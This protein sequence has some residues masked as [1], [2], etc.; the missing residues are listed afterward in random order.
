MTDQE[1]VAIVNAVVYIVPVLALIVSVITFFNASR[2]RHSKS[3]A[4]QAKI[5]VKL[6]NNSATLNDIKGTV[7]VLRDGYNKN[8]AAIEKLDTKIGG[9]EIRVDKVEQDIKELEN[10]VH[11]YHTH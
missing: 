6:D 7:D 4:E 1:F 10:K 9:L 8:H 11:L 2:E 5:G 3:A